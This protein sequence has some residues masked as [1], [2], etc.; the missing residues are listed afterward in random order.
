MVQCNT[1]M[2]ID[3]NSLGHPVQYSRWLFISFLS[4]ANVTSMLP[5]STVFKMNLG[6]KDSPEHRKLHVRTNQVLFLAIS[7]T[8]AFLGI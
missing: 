5:P 7:L 2:C 6:V 3:A 4:S 8:S 1:I